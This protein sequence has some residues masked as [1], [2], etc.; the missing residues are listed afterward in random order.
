M[1]SDPILPGDERSPIEV[2]CRA[3]VSAE[4]LRTM[5]LSLPDAHEAP[6]FDRTSFRVDE[7]IFA[8]MTKDGKEA[9]VKVQP[10]EKI[11][12]LLE[13]RPETFFSYGGWTTKGGALGIRLARIEVALLRGLLAEAHANLTAKR[14]A[15]K[16]PARKMGEKKVAARSAGQ[17]SKRRA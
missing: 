1:T 10:I 4:K 11:E 2:S 3:M 14:A 17:R 15:K 9:M 5:A 12:T 8:T 16:K 6:H 7:R 13:T